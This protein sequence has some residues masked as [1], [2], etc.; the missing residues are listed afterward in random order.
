M[1]APISAIL[2]VFLAAGAFA[3]SGCISVS[4]TQVSDDPR[5]KIAFENDRAARVFY[6]TLAS[7]VP[8]KPTTEKQESVSL[9]LV[10]VNKRTV[11]GPNRV[12]NEAVAFCDTDGNGEI[13]EAEAGIFAAEW[14]RFCARR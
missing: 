3:L 2:A 6:E 8:S 12:Y 7:D 10:N 11:T 5:V 9:I 14:P 13:T 4:E 1:K